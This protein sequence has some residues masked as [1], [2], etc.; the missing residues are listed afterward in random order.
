MGGEKCSVALRSIPRSGTWLFGS[1][2]KTRGGD[3]SASRASS[4]SSASVSVPPASGRSSGERGFHP[5]H[6][7]PV[8]RGASS[9]VR[10]PGE[11]SAVSPSAVDEVNQLM[12]SFHAGPS[13]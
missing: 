9:S 4:A 12:R 10:K 13:A 2:E 11:S 8:P 6:E 1:A 7:G 3:A 5:L